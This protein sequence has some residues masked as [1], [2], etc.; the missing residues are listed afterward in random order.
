LR[1]AA[2]SW[3]HDD[4][5]AHAGQLKRGPIVASRSR[6]ALLRWRKDAALAAVRDPAPL[7]K[8]PEAEQVAWLN[9]WAQVDALLAR[10]TRR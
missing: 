7:R 5:A 2:L 3:L 4:L 1:Y 9:L 10:T 8:L 6:Q